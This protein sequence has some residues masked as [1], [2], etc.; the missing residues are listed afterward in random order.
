MGM[1]SPGYSVF[2]PYLRAFQEIRGGESWSNVE[3]EQHAGGEELT[4]SSS[5]SAPREARTNPE[6][7]TAIRWRGTR[8]PPSAVFGSLDRD[9]AA[10]CCHPSERRARRKH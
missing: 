4:L 1:G 7:P 8:P 10:D 5:R 3:F 2:S 9:R 6:A